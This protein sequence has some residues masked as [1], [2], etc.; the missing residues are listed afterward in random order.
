MHPGTVPAGNAA[1]GQPV[2]RPVD[3]PNP[4]A[5]LWS[6]LRSR[7][8]DPPRPGGSQTVDH[9]GL[10]PV[11]KALANGGIARLAALAPDLDAYVTHLGSVDPDR[12][13]APEAK[14][15]WINLYNALALDLARRAAAG[16]AGTVLRMPGAFSRTAI[17]VEGEK[18]SLDGIEHGKIRRF[19]DPR[20]HSALVCGSLSCP[21]LRF[22]PFDA[23]VDEQ[24]DEQM[25]SFLASGAA[26]EDR[27]GQS[28]HLSRVFLWYGADFV[29][30][31][32]MPTLVPARRGLVARAIAE[33]LP[34]DTRAWIREELPSV[35]FQPYD[36]ALGCAVRPPS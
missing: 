15:F 2:G 34:P 19:G 23:R 21:T 30:P 22:E 33:W 29:K 4:F 26:V 31:H 12:L 25:R 6:M 27:A 16:G 17:E 14:A 11:L 10:T 36:W 28:L 13:S 7:N 18:L 8:L 5:A 3:G 20:I 35:R 9:S 24:L 1:A 32:R